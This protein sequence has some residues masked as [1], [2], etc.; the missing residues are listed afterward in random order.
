MPYLPEG[1]SLDDFVV[2]SSEKSIGILQSVKV[3]PTIA[4]DIKKNAVWAIIG[5]LTMYSCISY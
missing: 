5:S 3:G 1:I 4:D 2:G